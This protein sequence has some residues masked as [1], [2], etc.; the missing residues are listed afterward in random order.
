MFLQAI[1]ESKKE[2]LKER[3]TQHH[4]AGVMSLQPVAV[5]V[6]PLN[7]IWYVKQENLYQPFVAGGTRPARSP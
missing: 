1:L 4:V 6:S 7:V 2:V 3:S 5:Y